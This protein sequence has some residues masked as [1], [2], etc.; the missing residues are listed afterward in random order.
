SARILTEQ[1][2]APLIV[3]GEV[4]LHHGVRHAAIEVETAAVGSRTLIAVGDAVLNHEPVRVPPPDA[5]WSVTVTGHIPTIIGRDAILDQRAVHAADH[6]AVPAVVI[7]VFGIAG[8]VLGDAV[9]NIE[10]L[11]PGNFI[12]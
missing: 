2:P 5:D 6:D 1:I 3:V 9:P 10:I 7:Q 4:I 8:I 11:R 12:V